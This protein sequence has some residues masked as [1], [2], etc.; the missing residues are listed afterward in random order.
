[1]G[2]GRTWPLAMRLDDGIEV[3]V[4]PIEPDDASALAA[5]HEGLSERTQIRRFLGAKPHLSDADLHRFT[6]IDRQRRMAVV[7][8]RDG[9]IV[10]VARY[11]ALGPTEPVVEVA[12]VLAD[13]YQGHGLGTRLCRLIAELA[14][15]AGFREATASML[16]SNA[17]MLGAIRAAGFAPV[18]RLEA[19]TLEARFTLLE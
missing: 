4:R 13:A 3:S 10:G 15:E 12:F 11:E 19:G 1:M 9:L 5:F 14:R 17:A 16:P 18:Q 2:T 7:A 8:E 6:H